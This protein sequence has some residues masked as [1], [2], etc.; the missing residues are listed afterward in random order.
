MPDEAEEGFADFQYQGPTDLAQ[1][2][3]ELNM[4]QRHFT[5]VAARLQ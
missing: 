2:S 4:A 1:N 3:M 5:C